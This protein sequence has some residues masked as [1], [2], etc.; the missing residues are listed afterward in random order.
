MP[1]PPQNPAAVTAGLRPEH[2]GAPASGRTVD[3]REPRTPCRRGGSRRRVRPR[4]CWPTTVRSRRPPVSAGTIWPPSI[5]SKPGWAASRAPAPRARRGLCSS[6]RRP[7]PPTARAVTSTHARDSIM[8]AG[9]YLAAN[10][11]V[12]DPDHALYRYNNLT[13]VRRRSR[14]TRP[15]WPP[16][17]QRSTATPTG[18]CTTGPRPAT[19]CCPSDMHEP[20]PSR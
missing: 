8:A 4:N 16:I 6:C 9:R 5:S 14:I 18:R 13:I 2:R 1:C 7:S 10:G 3:R 11:F 20:A 19:C 12:T 15:C 17:P